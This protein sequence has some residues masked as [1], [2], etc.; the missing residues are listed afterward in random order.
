[1]VMR[2]RGVA[3]TIIASA[4]LAVACGSDNSSPTGTAAVAS[5]SVSAP[6]TA[7]LVGATATLTATPKDATGNAVSGA[8]VT[9][10]SS[11]DA[12]ATVSSTGTVTGVAP[13]TATITATSNGQ[14]GSAV[15]TVASK[16][17]T[18]KATMTP[19]NEVPPTS[20][21][22]SGTFTATLDTTNNLFTY[23]VTFTGLTSPVTLGHIHGPAVAGVN[24]GTTVN[25][26]TLPGATFSVG[27]TSGAA[28]GSL[29]LNAATPVTSSMSGDSLK[30]LLFAGLTYANVHTTIN[31]GGEIRGQISK[32]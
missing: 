22:G 31:G 30:K 5:V 9:W 23:D 19:A 12:I 20:S 15:V 14:T 2:N 26:G 7:I 8:T 18:F 3:L 11:S 1:M 29:T 27:A 25:F 21:T 32:Q 16:I 17:V 28:H 4:I 13:G 10:S 6:T 24:A